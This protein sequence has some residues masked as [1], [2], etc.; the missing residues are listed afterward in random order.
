[1]IV[2]FST[3]FRPQK[4]KKLEADNKISMT[5]GASNMN[6]VWG[7]NMSVIESQ[8]VFKH[9]Q[10]G[11]TWRIIPLRKQLVTPFYRP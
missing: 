11:S 10:F 3:I 7:A 2:C 1:M 9:V 4:L 6:F 5:F 8:F